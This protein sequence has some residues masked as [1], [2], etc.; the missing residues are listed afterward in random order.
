MSIVRDR[1]R[2]RL[3]VI[4]PFSNA[5]LEPDM[6]RMKGEGMSVHFMRAGGYDLNQVPD[7]EQMR[8]FADASLEPVLEAL[9][10]MRPHGIVYG[11]TSATLSHGLVY[12][13]QFVAR[14]EA[15]SGV[16]CVTAA[17]SLVCALKAVRAQRV[18]FGSPYTRQ[19]NEEGAA[20]LDGA[21][22]EVVNVGY[23]GEDLGNYGQSMLEPA[24]V[25]A[26][27]EKTD[28]PD[29]DV[30]VLSCTDMRAMEVIE[31]LETVLGKPVVTSNQASMYAICR[32]LSCGAELPGSLAQH[33]NNC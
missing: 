21:G 25:F 3:G 23:I 17:G 30:V 28:H 2:I 7:S 18:A 15:I 20:F 1:G 5:N 32:K 22:L 11:C 19:L 16:P 12:D 24:Q 31:A 8:Q 4:V 29:A 10:A 26:L 14:M 9:C 27:G 13:N 6:V 33:L